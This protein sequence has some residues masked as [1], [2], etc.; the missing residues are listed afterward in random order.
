MSNMFEQTKWETTTVYTEEKI[1]PKQAPNPKA[2]SQEEPA[3]KEAPAGVNDYKDD[4]VRLQAEYVNYRKRVE[5]DKDVSSERAIHSVLTSLVPVLDD[6]EAARKF[7]DIPED[8][9]LAAI[10]RKLDAALISNGLDVVE[11]SNVEFD[12]NIHEA[13]IAQ[14]VDGVEADTVAEV[15]RTGYTTRHGLIRA[16]QVM[17]AQ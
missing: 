8:G 10:L 17:V 1:T 9:P 5:R 7:G 3:P 16:A 2:T 12:P 13:V 11:E 15:F 6:I 14:P 4:L